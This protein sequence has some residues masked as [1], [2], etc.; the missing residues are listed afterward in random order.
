MHVGLFLIQSGSF[1]HLLYMSLR[2]SV[3]HFCFV[4]VDDMVFFHGMVCDG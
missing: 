3:D 1:I 4:P 2:L